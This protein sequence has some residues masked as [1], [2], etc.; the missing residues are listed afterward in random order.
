MTERIKPTS[1]LGFKKITSEETNKDVLQ[2][3][4]GDFFNLW[5]P[6]DEINVTVPYDIRSYEEY[7]KQ[8]SGGETI[9][10]KLRQTIQDVA[11]D[12]TIADFGAEIQVKAD[13]FFTLRSLYLAFARFCSNYNLPGKMVYRYDGTPIRY[14]SLKPM[15]YLNILGYP[16]FTGDDDALRILTFND[17]VRNKSLDR[18]YMTIAYFELDK[19]NIETVNQGYWKTFFKT[20]EAPDQAPEYIKKAARVIE[21]ANLTKE[22]RTMYDQLQKAQDIYDSVIYTAQIEGERIGEARGE[23]RGEVKGK[24][25]ERLVIARNA[26]HMGMTIAQ[27]SQLTGVAEDE[28]RKLAQ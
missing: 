12:I 17:S 1:D 18:E 25:E 19:N 27:A 22:E 5:I 13:R 2:G 20:G 28:I 6:L 24:V 21:R 23:A 16:H 8:L 11:A 3:I 10:E 14:S 26:L 7:L 15:Y 4:I 9:S